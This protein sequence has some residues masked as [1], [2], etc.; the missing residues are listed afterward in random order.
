MRA[1]VTSASVDVAS[2]Q[3]ASAMSLAVVRDAAAALDP[4]EVL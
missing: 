1:T 2:L 3:T 4:H